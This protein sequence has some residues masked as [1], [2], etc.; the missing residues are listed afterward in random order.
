M[1]SS[2]AADAVIE[3][4]HVVMHQFRS[5]QFQALRDGAHDVTHMEAK[6][7]GFFAHR[8]GATLSDLVVHSG[9]DKAQL[10]KLV[11]GLRERG[12]LAAESDATDRRSVRLS[13]SAAGRAAQHAM[14]AEGRVLN[15]RA[16]AGLSAKEQAQLVDLL[17]R[18]KAN[19]DAP[20]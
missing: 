8:P 10:A 1:D 13:L 11:K 6:V 5:R 20:D 2:S 16:L 7:M 12:L 14:R 17:G 15:E 9:R 19:L 18:V 3:L 4:V